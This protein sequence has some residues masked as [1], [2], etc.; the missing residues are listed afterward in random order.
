MDCDYQI[1][2]RSIDDSMLEIGA[3]TTIIEAWKV[4]NH[5][6]DLRLLCSALESE[7]PNVTIPQ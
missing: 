3:F 7:H 2:I 5:L 6:L 1:L 4:R